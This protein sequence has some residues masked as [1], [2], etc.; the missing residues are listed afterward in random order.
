MSKLAWLWL[1]GGLGVMACLSPSSEAYPQVWRWNWEPPLKADDLLLEGIDAKNGTYGIYA[2]TLEPG[3]RRQKARLLIPGGMQPVW[4]PQRNYLAY[5]E[6]DTPRMARRDGQEDVQLRST[7]AFAGGGRPEVHLSWWEGEIDPSWG[8]GEKG[9]EKGLVWCFPQPPGDTRT[10]VGGGEVIHSWFN[11][12]KG[13]PEGQ[14]IDY[15]SFS[16]DTHEI[17]AET[18]PHRAFNLGRAEARIRRFRFLEAGDHLEEGDKPAH[19]PARTC[20]TSLGKRVTQHEGWMAELQPLWSPDGEWIAFTGVRQEGKTLAVVARP[21]GREETVLIAGL[22]M[23]TGGTEYIPMGQG[24]PGPEQR[25][26]PTYPVEWAPKG[27]RLL[28]GQ[29]WEQ[30]QKLA[31]AEFDGAR[32]RWQGTWGIE[33]VGIS[34]IRFPQWTP[35]G[36]RIAYL[37]GNAPNPEGDTLVVVDVEKGEIYGQKFALPIRLR[38]LWLDW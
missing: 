13:Q 17:V 23:G 14:V 15:I 9:I 33:M 3:A 18:Y 8:I 10:F 20:F 27:A 32:W 36:K 4:S 12:E 19:T 22:S 34:S 26:W 30:Y 31:V 21:D 6:G 24:I 7:V 37:E 28:V 29:G 5:L 16:P 1:M 25:Y 38:I 35:D 11:E 2:I